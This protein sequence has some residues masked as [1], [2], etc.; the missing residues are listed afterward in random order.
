[1]PRPPDYSDLPAT[2]DGRATDHEE[3]IRVLEKCTRDT[4]SSIDVLRLEMTGVDKKLDGALD[5]WG[6]DRDERA[7]GKRW[8]IGLALSVVLALSG[9]V[10]AVIQ[11]GTTVEAI[12]AEVAEHKGQEGH[13]SI[14]RQVDR[15]EGE[16]EAAERVSRER[17]N[18][19]R[20]RIDAVE[21]AQKETEADIR[22]LRRRRR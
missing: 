9:G 19:A 22:D 1:M 10:V 6:K 8:L 21:R 13:P 5:A 2:G 7:S 20:M 12:A 14:Q 17:V 16:V 11:T 15:I 18:A 4:K 3:R